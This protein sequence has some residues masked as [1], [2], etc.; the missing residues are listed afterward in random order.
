MCLFWGTAWPPPKHVRLALLVTKSSVLV[1][2]TQG[3]IYLHFLHRFHGKRDAR[4]SGLCGLV[5]VHTQ[6]RIS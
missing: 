5:L 6:V 3:D 2:N 4:L 1:L